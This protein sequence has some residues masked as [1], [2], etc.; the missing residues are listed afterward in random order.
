MDPPSDELAAFAVW[1]LEQTL[2][3]MSRSH[4]DPA[5]VVWWLRDGQREAA[6]FDDGADLDAVRATEIPGGATLYAIVYAATHV[7]DGVS[8]D[9]L[10]AEAGDAS[11]EYRFGVR[12]AWTDGEPV[13]QGGQINVSPSGPTRLR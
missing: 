8:S 12:Y 10:V 7:L 9:A 13:P 3:R 5:P 6:L 4:G 11:H 2:G 1:T